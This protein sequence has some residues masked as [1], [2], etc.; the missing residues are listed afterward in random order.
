LRDS[1]DTDARRA[2]PADFDVTWSLGEDDVAGFNAGSFAATEEVFYG[3]GAAGPL[4]GVAG[5]L[6]LDVGADGGSEE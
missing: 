5:V 2:F 6:E 1:E 4:I 3:H